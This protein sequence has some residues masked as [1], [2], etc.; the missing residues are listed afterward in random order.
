[1]SMQVN[2]GRNSLDVLEREL[3]PVAVGNPQKPSTAAS[4]SSSTGR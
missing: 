3:L 2:L 1:M 4:S